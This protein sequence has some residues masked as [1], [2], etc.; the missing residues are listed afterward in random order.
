MKKYIFLFTFHFLLLFAILSCERQEIYPSPIASV[1]GEYKVLC[2]YQDIG[3]RMTVVAKNDSV[4]DIRVLSDYPN[5]LTKFSRVFKDVKIIPHQETPLGL[6]SI[7]HYIYHPIF[8]G[9]VRGY[10][11]GTYFGFTSWDSVTDNFATVVG[12]KIKED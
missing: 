8:I 2:C 6:D 4:V 7:T 12:T 3:R 5:S 11:A 1:I 9:Y 10:S